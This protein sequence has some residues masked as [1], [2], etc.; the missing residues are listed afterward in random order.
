VNG[1]Q[2]TGFTFSGAD[3]TPLQGNVGGGNANED[4]C[5]FGQVVVGYAGLLAMEGWHGQIQAMCN[6][7]DLQKNGSDYVV[8]LKPGATLPLRGFNGSEPWTSMCPKDQM[9][10][11][12]EGRSGLYID[13]FALHCAPLTI[14][15]S[16]D[17]YALSVGVVA[18]MA[19]VG[20]TGGDAFPNTDCPMGEIAT[21]SRIRAG[22]YVDALG[23]VCA[24]PLLTF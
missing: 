14:T 20:D 6:V 13:A 16:P 2:P 23:L 18:I 10:V 15:Q 3:E 8:R 22:D 12:F 24:K 4:D 7:L 11:G 17:G 5:P 19:S 9:V 1:G 21:G